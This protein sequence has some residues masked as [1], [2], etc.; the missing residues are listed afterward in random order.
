MLIGAFV[1]D[2]PDRWRELVIRQVE[3]VAESLGLETEDMRGEEF[4][5]SE[6]VGKPTRR[7]T[8]ETYVVYGGEGEEEVGPD[9]LVGIGVW[10]PKILIN[11]VPSFSVKRRYRSE[12][13]GLANNIV[14]FVRRMVEQVWIRI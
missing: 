2:M 11:D 3:L 8:G 5:E 13:V 10:N 4:D 9:Q 7:K 14:R 12:W 6:Q 1:S